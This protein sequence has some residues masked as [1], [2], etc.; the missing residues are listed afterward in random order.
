MYFG[1]SF[2][3]GQ[4]SKSTTRPVVEGRPNDNA[5]DNGSTEIENPTT[6]AATTTVKPEPCAEYKEKE[7]FIEHSQG[8]IR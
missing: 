2:A 7:T 4:T 6:L 3:V 8:F 5:S 1:I